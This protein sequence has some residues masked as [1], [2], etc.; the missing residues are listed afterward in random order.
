MTIKGLSDAIQQGMDDYYSSHPNDPYFELWLEGR[1][2]ARRIKLEYHQYKAL[3]AA[4]KAPVELTE[5]TADKMAFRKSFFL[6]LSD[7]AI[8]FVGPWKHEY[9]NDGDAPRVGDLEA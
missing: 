6:H 5:W 3:E 9:P 2:M 7:T 1:V 8:E 4:L